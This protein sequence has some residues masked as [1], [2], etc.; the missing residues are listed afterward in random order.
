MASAADSGHV[1]VKDGDVA[2]KRTVTAAASFEGLSVTTPALAR[3]QMV[4]L[5]AEVVIPVLAFAP[6]ARLIGLA[7]RRRARARIESLKTNNCLLLL[8]Q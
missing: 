7:S 1:G 2:V 5:E 4:R 6:G 8:A 3:R